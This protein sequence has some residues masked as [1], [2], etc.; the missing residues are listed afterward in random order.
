MKKIKVQMRYIQAGLATL[1]LAASFFSQANYV[2]KNITIDNAESC[3]KGSFETHELWVNFLTEQSLKTKKLFNKERFVKNMPKEKFDYV[4]NNLEC[5]N[6]TYQ[7]D[8]LTIEGYYLKPR[9]SFNKKLPVLIYNRGGNGEY[10]YVKFYSK[11]DF[12]ADIA[13]QGFIVIGSQYRGSS[14]YIK[15]NGKDEFGGADINDVLALMQLIRHIPDAD[16]NRIGMM[17]KSRGGMQTF[18]AAKSLPN[19]KA[20]AIVAGNNDEEMAL[21]RRPKMERVLNYRVPNFKN[22]RAEALYK[23]SAI[24]WLDKLPQGAPILL[25]HG[26]ND[27]RVHVEQ[28][29]QMAAALKNRSH[30]HKLVVYPEG[31]HGL[32]KYRKE[33]NQELTS[34]FKKYL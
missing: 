27:K 33:V 4:K 9:N 22:N 1:F 29:I 32:W 5:I 17:G 20:I 24:K 16:I 21:K 11:I 19:I 15:N 26:D 23:R 34:W 12:I 3:F 31:N 13:K 18:I 10:G 30:E 6:F 25:L 2:Q 14:K 28:A 7:V 8:G